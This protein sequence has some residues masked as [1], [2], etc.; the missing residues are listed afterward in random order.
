MQ[1]LKNSKVVLDKPL[2]RL[3]LQDEKCHLVHIK[4]NRGESIPVHKN[5]VDVVFYTIKGNG[6][7]EVDGKEYSITE[8]DTIAVS[9]DADRGLRNTGDSVMEVL[10]VKLML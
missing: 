8:G 4:F 7:A 10:V 5:D 9:A 3:L 2:G 6:T 1:S